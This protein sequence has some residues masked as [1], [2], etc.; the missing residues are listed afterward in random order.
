VYRVLKFDPGETWGGGVASV[1]DM[2]NGRVE[3]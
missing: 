2:P 1:Q 3:I